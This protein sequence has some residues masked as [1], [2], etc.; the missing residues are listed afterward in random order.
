M[1][2]KAKYR[3]GVYTL[4]DSSTHESISV[5]APIYFFDD[6]GGTTLK[7]GAT[8]WTAK[9]ISVAG[10]TVEAN[11]ADQH[12]GIFQLAMDAQD[13]EQEAGMTWGNQLN[14][15]MDKGPIIEFR[16][17]LHTLPTL[18]TEIYFGVAN[19]Y[20]KGRL[21]AAD[22]G[23]TVHAVFHFSIFGA[24]AGGLA[25]IYTDD[26]STDNGPVTTGVTVLADAYHI[27]KIDFTQIA[28]VL[29]YIDGVR[30]ANTTTF[31][32]ANGSN[33]VV[34]PYLMVY[35]DSGAGL[36]DVYFDYVKV[37]SKR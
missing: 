16:A 14:F 32:M 28:N 25:E 7:A 9:D 1:T 4:F 35:K 34:Q 19:D 37:W 31:S 10:T 22:E 11:L 13:E 27:F 15:N 3:N 36:G 6:F 26:D 2:T 24:V 33:V 30:V 18:L 29:F 5:G 20:V 21:A 23:P 12:G 17:A 8:I